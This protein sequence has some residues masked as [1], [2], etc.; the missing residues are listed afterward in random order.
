M[1]Q[2]LFKAAITII[3]IA[4]V[5]GIGHYKPLYYLFVGTFLLPIVFAY[6]NLR[7]C[8]YSWGLITVIVALFMTNY[9]F[10]LYGGGTYDQVGKTLCDISIVVSIILLIP[11]FLYFKRYHID[12][13]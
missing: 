2:Y 5:V 7:R 12:S 4:I 9:L 11:V 6:I 3:V 1:K 13:R 10:R 8:N